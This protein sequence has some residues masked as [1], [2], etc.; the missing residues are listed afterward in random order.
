MAIVPAYFFGKV[1]QQAEVNRSVDK[2]VTRSSDMVGT[3]SL[4]N[5]RCLLHGEDK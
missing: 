2:V 3:H 5:S 1:V 4:A